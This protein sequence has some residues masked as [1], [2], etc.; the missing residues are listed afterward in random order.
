MTLSL[1]KIPQKRKR[2]RSGGSVSNKYVSIDAR[3]A[4]PDVNHALIMTD[5]FSKVSAIL[6]A[7]R[8]TVAEHVKLFGNK[9]NE[10]SYS[11]YS[12][13]LGI[14]TALAV[15]LHSH[16]SRGMPVATHNQANLQKHYNYNVI[17]VDDDLAAWN[18]SGT[19][20]VGREKLAK[21]F[22][23]AFK[24]IET[25]TDSE[26]SEF[27]SILDDASI[28]NEERNETFRDNQNRASEVV[29]AVYDNGFTPA[30]RKAILDFATVQRKDD[31]ENTGDETP[32]TPPE[33][34][35]PEVAASK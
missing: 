27:Q 25:M 24:P 31:G 21:V 2:S 5:T 20:V 35:T 11:D 14:F 30:T 26:K 28:A 3:E 9:K 17:R 16:G 1:G 13:F 19:E 23:L 10:Y 12:D 6:D 32:A 15:A 7:M 29:Q 4:C 22:K 33:N 8:D 34:P 18:K